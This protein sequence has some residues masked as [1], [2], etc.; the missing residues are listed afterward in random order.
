MAVRRTRWKLLEGEK[1]STK[2]VE[3]IL[4]MELEVGV[5]ASGKAGQQPVVWGSGRARSNPATE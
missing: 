5:R 3:L 1:Q 2:V 4:E